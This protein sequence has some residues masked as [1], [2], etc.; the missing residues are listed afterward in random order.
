[1][2]SD[3][4]KTVEIAVEAVEDVFENKSEKLRKPSRKVE[5]VYK[6]GKV[7]GKGGFGTVYAGIRRRDGKTVAIKQIAKSK[8]QTLEMVSSSSNKS[9]K[10]ISSN[11]IPKLDKLLSSQHFSC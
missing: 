1:M 11:Y 3:K 5:K 9:T 8:V 10:C 4:Y 6:I 2:C 7:L